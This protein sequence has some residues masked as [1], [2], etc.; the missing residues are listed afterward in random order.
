MTRQY[1]AGDL[2]LEEG[3]DFSTPVLVAP[4][5]PPAVQLMRRLE[6]AELALPVVIVGTTAA[7]SGFIVKQHSFDVRD[8]DLLAETEGMPEVERQ[9][10]LDLLEHAARNADTAGIGQAFQPRRHIDAV[11]EQVAIPDHHVADVDADAE[12]QFSVVRQL[13]VTAQNLFLA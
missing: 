10:M 3:V 4:E 8:Y 5:E 1:K 2:I 6:E 11:A 9:L 13:R 7:G 12:D